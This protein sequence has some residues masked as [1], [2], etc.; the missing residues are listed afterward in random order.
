LKTIV[1]VALV[2]FILAS[3]RSLKVEE[4][5]HQIAKSVKSS[6][7]YS[8]D[9]KKEILSTL[10]EMNSEVKEY[11][12]ASTS[13]KRH[14]KKD[15]KEKMAKLKEEMPENEMVSHHTTAHKSFEEE[16]EEAQKRVERVHQGIKDLK[17]EL[18]EKVL[19][20]SDKKAAKTL[21]HQLESEYTDLVAESSKEGRKRVAKQMK[22]TL[23]KLRTHMSAEK[24]TKHSFASKHSVTAKLPVAAKH[25]S[26]LEQSTKQAKK[27]KIMKLVKQTELEYQEKSLPSDVSHKIHAK[28]EQMK[29]DLKSVTDLHLLKTKLQ[30]TLSAIKAMEKSVDLEEKKEEFSLEEDEEE[31]EKETKNVDNDFE[32]EDDDES[33]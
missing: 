24:E 10:K 29:D 11:D 3:P 31:K 12:S 5:L 2:S 1:F 25:H 22:E 23:A 30:S 26:E 6:E 27:D 28:F 9:E 32:E 21:Y 16:E 19:S 18:K 13:E 15:L 17:S 7:K 4:D 33:L 20:S 14:L 8:V